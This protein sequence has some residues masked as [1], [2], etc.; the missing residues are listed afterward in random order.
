MIGRQRNIGS[1]EMDQVATELIEAFDEILPGPPVERRQMFGYPAGFV[2]GNMFCGLFQDSMLLRLD[3]KTRAKLL[4]VKVAK[5]FSPMPGKESKSF[6]AVPLSMVEDHD[7]IGP[8]LE[9][10][11]NFASKMPPKKKKTTLKK[12]KTKK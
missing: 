6:V 1:H 12:K 4:K 10:A 3:E 8:W 7:V 2:N 5:P 11:L 9:A